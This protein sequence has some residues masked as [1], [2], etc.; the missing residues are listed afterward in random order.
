MQHRTVAELMSREV[1]SARREMPFKDVVRLLADNDVTA[2]PVVDDLHRPVGVVSE[3]DLLR[4]SADQA[5]PSG[6]LPYPT[7]THWSA[8]RRKRSVPR[9]SC[10]LPPCAPVRT[11]PWWR[12]PA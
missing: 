3:A 10:R 6:R 2:V 12:P 5:D 8:P 9:S 7:W 4:K 11:G 1:I